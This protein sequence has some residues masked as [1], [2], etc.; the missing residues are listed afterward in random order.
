MPG[1]HDIS[2]LSPRG[3]TSTM[4]AEL[5]LTDRLRWQRTAHGLWLEGKRFDIPRDVNDFIRLLG[6]Q[7]PL[8]RHNTRRVLSRN[9]P[10]LS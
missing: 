4:L 6:E 5:G 3:G 1:V 8:E 10:G 2:G 7:F 9:R